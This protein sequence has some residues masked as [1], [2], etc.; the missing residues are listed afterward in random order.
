MACM[1]CSPGF[2]LT[3]HFESLS[4]QEILSAAGH[5]SLGLVRLSLK[6]SVAGPVF[7]EQQAKP[8]S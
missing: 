4:E 2:A 8:L 5:F 1:I 3:T 6:Q 7:V